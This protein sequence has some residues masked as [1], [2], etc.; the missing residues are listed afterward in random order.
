[1]REHAVTDWNGA[2]LD[3]SLLVGWLYSTRPIL[4]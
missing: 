1:M 4:P 2:S 3:V